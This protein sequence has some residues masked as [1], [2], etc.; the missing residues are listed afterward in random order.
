MC[1]WLSLKTVC[2]RSPI[3]FSLSFL[4]ICVVMFGYT[5]YIMEREAQPASFSL[6][7]GLF[8]AF[9]CFSMNW[10]ADVYEDYNP[11]TWGGRLTCVAA[12]CSGLLLT[13]FII[14]VVTQKL[15]PTNFENKALHFLTMERVTFTTYTDTFS[16]SF[17]H[18]FLICSL[19]P[20]VSS[21]E[22]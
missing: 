12:A 15:M 2:F 17:A 13:S 10:A 22:R 7:S 21:I 8:V 11:I 3:T 16:I 19:L 6:L 18:Y 9:Q 4:I 14:G 5:L 20:F 1:R